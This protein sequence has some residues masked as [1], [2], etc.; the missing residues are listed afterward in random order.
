MS[1]MNTLYLRI[2]PPSWR[3][4]SC[5][6][7]CRAGSSSATSSS[8]RAE[9]REAVARAPRRLGRTGA[10]QPAARGRPVGE[11]RE[12][13][14]ASP[15]ACTCRSRSTAPAASA[16]P[17]RRCS[18]ATRAARARG[19]GRPAH[20]LAAAG[21]RAHAVGAA[22]GHAASRRTDAHAS[23]AGRGLA[24]DPAPGPLAW[25]AG[26]GAGLVVTLAVLFAAISIGAYPV[27]AG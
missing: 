6:R 12:A 20:R 9:G 3:C 19:A 18:A 7:W 16:S 21:R 26:P 14:L 2:Y 11:Q 17:R 1:P 4:C 5:S 13:L 10:E 25:L 27:V 22:P 8:A 15:S 24:G 23:L